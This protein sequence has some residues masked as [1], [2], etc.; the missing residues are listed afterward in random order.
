MLE[1]GSA[2]LAGAR[3][4]SLKNERIVDPAIAYHASDIKNGGAT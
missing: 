1:E 4:S 3:I 2:F